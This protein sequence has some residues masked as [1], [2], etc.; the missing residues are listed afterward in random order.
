[1]LC[2]CHTA[3]LKADLR[4]LTLVKGNVTIKADQLGGPKMLSRIMTT[5]CALALT[6]GAASAEF[7]LHIVHINDLHS[8]IEPINR[9]DSTCNAED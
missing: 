9:F 4:R 7:S 2:N 8:R 5:T 6:A 3:G 1:M